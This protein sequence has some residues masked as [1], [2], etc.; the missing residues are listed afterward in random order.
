MRILFI[1]DE[2]LLRECIYEMLS[3][4]LVSRHAGHQQVSDDEVESPRVLEEDTGSSRKGMR[5]S[6]YDKSIKDVKECRYTST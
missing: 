1:D 4:N 5:V 3:D 2:E 6:L